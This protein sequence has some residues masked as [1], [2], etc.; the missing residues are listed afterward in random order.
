MGKLIA[1]L[2]SFGLLAPR[3]KLSANFENLTCEFLQVQ[4]QSLR[5]YIAKLETEQTDR[6][7]FHNDCISR[8]ENKIK[9]LYIKNAKQAYLIQAQE[10]RSNTASFVALSST[11]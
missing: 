11:K 1:F 10:V 4:N 5:L 8:L 2:V 6:S 3:L 7:R 9:E